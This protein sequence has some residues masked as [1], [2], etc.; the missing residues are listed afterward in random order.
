M[1]A[2]RLPV[3]HDARA[4]LRAERPGPLTLG[5]TSR[6]PLRLEALR[7]RLSGLETPS[8]AA[9]G[10]PFRLVITIENLSASTWPGLDP[11]PAGLVTLRARWANAAG[12]SVVRGD[13]IP[14]ARDLGTG[15][16]LRTSATV[17]APMQPGRY[18]LELALEQEGGPAFEG[19]AAEAS[20]DVVPWPFRR[21]GVKSL[22]E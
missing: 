21:E 12:D 20:V 13:S 8:R 4:A 15:E 6:A 11:F 10:T 2:V 5:G 1:F 14:L 19:A 9:T 3:R 18:R 7:G 22:F 17:M 16:T